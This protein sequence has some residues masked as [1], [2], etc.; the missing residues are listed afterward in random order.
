MRPYIDF[1]TR[2]RTLATSTE[3]KNL[4]KLANNAVFGRTCLNLRKQVDVRLSNNVKQS[5]RY[6]AYPTYES[7]TIINE[8]LVMIKLTKAS[9]Y[10]NKPTY[11]GF[12]ILDLSKEHMYAMHYDVILPQYGPNAKLLF[13]DT[14]SL[15]YELKTKDYYED[16]LSNMDIFDTSNFPPTHKCYSNRNCKVLGKFKEECGP[17]QPLQFVGLRAKMYSI[18]MSDAQDK[19]TAKGIKTSYVKKYLK[20]E[21]YYNCLLNQSKTS[22]SF[23]SIRAQ[24]H[25]I[26]TVHI[27]K[28]GLNPYDDKRYLLENSTDTLSYGHYRLRK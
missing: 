21:D 27:K 11:V 18:K 9:I 14:D 8:D 25:K 15:C 16:I 22:A 3:D 24:N 2:Q 7:H 6:V 26:Q 1:N 17:N 28:D 10:W 13:T 5:K 4:F 12:S 19:S 23:Y 20:H